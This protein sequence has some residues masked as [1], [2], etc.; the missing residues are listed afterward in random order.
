MK[1]RKFT[2]ID[3]VKGFLMLQG[4]LFLAIKVSGWILDLGVVRRYMIRL[5]WSGWLKQWNF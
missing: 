1:K 3:K 4:I 5:A 2:L